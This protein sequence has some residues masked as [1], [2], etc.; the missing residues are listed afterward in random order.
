MNHRERI[1]GALNHIKTDRVPIDFGSTTVSGISA[2]VVSKLRDY[3]GLPNHPPVKVIEPYQMLGEINSDLGE[4]LGIDCIP[5]VGKTNLFGFDNDNWKEWELFDG[6]P[7]LVPG[8]FNTLP[9]KDGSLL[10]YPEGDMSSEPSAKMP[11]GG[12]YF[13]SIKRQLSIDN[14]NLKIED[15]LEEFKIISEKELN[16]I[17]KR[18][19]YCFTETDYAIVANF[20]GMSFGDIAFIPAPFLKNPKGIRDV[21]EW[22]IS[23]VSR[24]KY[25]FNI[26]SK[27]C[28]IAIENL[29]RL[30]KV[31]DNRISVIFVTGTDFG[32]QNSQFISNDLYRELFRPFH[33]KIN[34]WIHENT[35]WKTFIHSCGAIEPL[36]LEFIE[37]GF[38]IINPVQLS[39]SGM[40]AIELKNKYGKRLIFWGGG[41]DT[42]KILPFGSPKDV[43]KEVEKR[44]RDFSKDGGFIFNTIHNIQPNTPIENIAI[45]VET[46]N[47]FSV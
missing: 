29:K 35:Q 47:K 32:A 8:K 9:E 18:I 1:E 4:I 5:L 38:D 46:I 36:I 26:F 7:V 24:K 37:A 42:Q 43:K 27:Q 10:Q 40:D 41:V 39:A 33:I 6:T 15:N 23:L 20:G 28:E 22:Y 25:V 2:S 11:K 30:F 19:N 12:F 34:N 3:Y 14:D 21:Q 45:M 44:L 13:D 17:K 31:V 16:F